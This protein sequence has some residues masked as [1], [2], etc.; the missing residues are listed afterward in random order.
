MQAASTALR[1]EDRNHQDLF[2]PALSCA[3]VVVFFE[4]AAERIGREVRSR[5]GIPQRTLS[6]NLMVAPLAMRNSTCLDLGYATLAKETVLVRSKVADLMETL[7]P[8][9]VDVVTLGRDCAEICQCNHGR[10]TRRGVHLDKAF[11]TV[12]ATT[13][14]VLKPCTILYIATIR[15]QNSMRR[16]SGFAIA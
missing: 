15:S 9:A 3:K 2:V 8:G 14:D 1:R 4:I 11:R 7:P 10:L 12:R 6:M 16:Y 13:L 5:V